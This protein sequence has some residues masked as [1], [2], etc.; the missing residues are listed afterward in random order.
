[1][2]KIILETNRHPEDSAMLQA[3]YS[4]SSQ[5]VEDHQEKLKTSPSGTFMEKY[6][7]GYG[8]ASIGE[9]AQF[10]LFLEDIPIQ[11]A[12]KIQESPLYRGQERSTRYVKMDEMKVSPLLKDQESE[13]QPLLDLANEVYRFHTVRLTKDGLPPKQVHAAACDLS[14]GFLPLG[15]ATSLSWATDIRTFREHV[16][17]ILCSPLP[18]WEAEW[19]LK[20]WDVVRTE[21][22]NSIGEPFSPN[23]GTQSLFV[24][25]LPKPTVT[26]FEGVEAY[27]KRPTKAYPIPRSWFSFPPFVMEFHLDLGA[28][29]ELHRHRR[30]TLSFPQSEG[31][32]HSFY[33]ALLGDSSLR[34][35]ANELSFPPLNPKDSR[36]DYNAVLGQVCRAS[37]WLTIPQVITLLEA[38]SSS[39][40]HPI[41][42]DAMLSLYTFFLHNVPSS[43]HHGLFLPPDAFTRSAKKRATQTIESR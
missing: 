41:L 11:T 18:P 25:S 13:L 8:H 6:Y 32:L 5:S 22:P 16:T 35:Q 31:V 42:Q 12:L 33:T 29:R 2:T 9:C 28:W 37:V 21:F 43:F 39:A 19:F 10:V 34:R 3:L 38:R 24:P 36:F 23:V 14:R 1:M 26:S 17:S 15:T 40:V 30:M 4:R 27:E 7:I 20:L